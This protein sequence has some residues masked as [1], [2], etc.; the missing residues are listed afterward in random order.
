MKVS[1]FGAFALIFMASGSLQAQNPGKEFLTPQDV[2]RVFAATQA[3][4][5]RVKNDAAVEY[6][7]TLSWG[8]KV[9]AELQN[10][11]DKARALNCRTISIIANL[12]HPENASRAE[13]L[14]MVN[15]NNKRDIYGRAFLN[16]RDQIIARMAFIATGN[17]TLRG[18]VYT[19]AGWQDHAWRFYIALYDKKDPGV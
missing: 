1:L 3:Q 11:E 6:D 10:C 15:Q 16:D 12:D 4:A 2:E 7:V 17:E 19:F 9:N 5:V 18:L 14:E 13:L 8:P